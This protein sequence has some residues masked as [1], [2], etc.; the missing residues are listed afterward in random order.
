MQISYGLEVLVAKGG[1]F[2]KV[3][4]VDLEISHQ[5]NHK[6]ERVLETF[7]GK[8]QKEVALGNTSMLFAVGVA[9]KEDLDQAI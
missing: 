4:R 5:E 2:L 9:G 7:R 8:T 3:I 1:L 6:G